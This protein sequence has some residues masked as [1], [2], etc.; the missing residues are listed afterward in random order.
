MNDA[1]KADAATM[2]VLYDT[3]AGVV[4]ALCQT[5]PA[6]QKQAFAGSLARLAKNAEARGAPQL[7][8]ALLDMYR[9][10]TL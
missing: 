4:I 9:A 1:Y 6:A 7:E 3:L 10:S 5:M 2:A 8:A